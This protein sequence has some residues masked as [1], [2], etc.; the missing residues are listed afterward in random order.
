MS[1]KKIGIVFNTGLGD[2]LMLIP[3]AK[4]LKM[5]AYHVSAIVCSKYISKEVLDAFNLFDE[6][7]EIKPDKWSIAR[8][9]CTHLLTYDTYLMSYSSS[10]WLW[11]L[12]G[13]FISRKVTTNRQKWYLR[14]I[15]GICYEKIKANEHVI[16]QNIQLANN[17]F[18]DKTKVHFTYRNIFPHSSSPITTSLSLKSGRILSITKPYLVV[19]V[20]ASNNVVQYKNWKIEYWIQFL[21]H[22][23]DNYGEQKIFLLGDGNEVTY[24]N[25]ITEAKIPNITSLIGETSMLNAFDLVRNA[26]CYVGLDSGLMHA[27]ALMGKATFTLWGPTSPKDYGYE[28]FNK[29]IHRDVCYYLPCHPCKSWINHN[30]VRVKKPEDC[31]D[32]AC[33]ADMH[34]QYITDEFIKFYD[35]LK[36]VS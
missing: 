34:P 6:I 5:E 22:I 10:S 25:K 1:A 12:V 11:A 17:L 28:I 19:Q 36:N 4:I 20:S 29:S 31:P 26:A 3:L 14:L 35:G 16:I 21:Q 33:L 27:A 24:A 30:T 2:G 9:T 8:F 7:I 13:I 15:P 32:L 18:T 23:S